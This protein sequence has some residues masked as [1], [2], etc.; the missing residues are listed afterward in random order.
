MSRHPVQKF[1][2]APLFIGSVMFLFLLGLTQYLAYERYLL[3]VETEMHDLYNEA[4]AA[5]SRLQTVLGNSVTTVQTLGFI[6]EH[7]GKP[8]SFDS[9]AT[10]LLRS[11]KY[12]DIIQLVDKDGVITD[13]Y[14]LPGNESVIG[15]NILKDSIRNQGAFAAIKSGAFFWAGPIPLK[16]GGVGII[17]RQPLYRDGQFNGFSAVV[18]KLSTFLKGAG[19]D[20]K[21]ISPYSYQLSRVNPGTHS[22]EFFLPDSGT[23][24]RAYSIPI[25][26]PNGEWKLY[27]SRKTGS[28]FYLTATFSLLGIILSI[29]GGVFAWFMAR[30]PSKLNNLVAEKT[31]QLAASEKYFRA[32]IEQ[33]SDA[34]ILMDRSGKVLYQSPS[35]TRVSGYAPNELLGVD[36]LTLIHPD[37]RQTDLAFFNALRDEPKATRSHMHYLRHKNGNY[38][39]IEGTYTNLLND[40]SV[41]AIVF[42]YHDLS[43]VL[44]EKNLSDS[45]INSLPGV[46]YLYDQS[47][48]FLKWNKNFET[49]SGYSGAEIQH[50]HPL[51]FFDTEE[52]VLLAEKI[53][54][55]F[56]KGMAEVEAPF[57][58][59]SGSKVDYYFNGYLIDLD[60]KDYLV[61]MGIDI[62]QRKKAELA[63]V[64]EKNLSESIINSLPGLFYL[65]DLNGRFLRWNKNFE[66]VS[67]YTANEISQMRVVQF[68]EIDD[69]EELLNKKALAIE[70]GTSEVEAR[71]LTKDKGSITFYF[72]SMLSSYNSGP[73]LLGVGIDITDRK[74]AQEA[75][76][77]RT[78][79]LN[80]RVKELNCLYQISEISN[81]FQLTVDEM[82]SQCIGILALSLQYSAV[83]CGRIVLQG[84]VYQTPNFKEKVWKLKADIVMNDN[85]EGHI[86]VCYLEERPMEY[87]GP[88]FKEER[89]LIDSVARV[90]SAALVRKQAEEGLVRSQN[91]LRQLSAH[92]QTIREEERTSI[93]RE[94]HDELGQQLTGLKMDA[95][96]LKKLSSNQD[97]LD[98]V[99]NMIDLI[100]D[101][102]KTVRRIS[103]ELRPGILDDLGLSSALEWQST[104]FE[105]R[106]GIACTFTAEGVTD[107]FSRDVATGVFRIYQ[108][109]LT[110]VARHAQAKHVTTT[111][112]QNSNQFVL[113]IS[114]DGVGFDMQDAGSK[115]TLG[116]LGMRERAHMFNGKL[117]INSKTGR[118]TTIVLTVPLHLS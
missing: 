45:I 101:T 25:Q 117:E 11:N 80:E 61:G 14:P 107:S 47:G 6:V 31:I 64:A 26:M 72:T 70:K 103:S 90:I 48:S 57:L 27:V 55:V 1:I 39:W 96:W 21:L 56:S 52:K 94:I 87:E 5:E 92:L 60:G 114:D 20:P 111:V 18:I 43:E 110:N 58:H 54:D 112:Q 51:D 16:Q 109:T 41:N 81:N 104:E 36:C 62:T 82:A 30:Q 42:N 23:S 59:K 46:F 35:T 2:T 49:V 22:E 65:A 102:I 85:V 77:N 66:T 3:L 9:I 95:S 91:E 13:V 83:A 118:G 68:V 10:T 69:R 78:M 32:L 98:K 19:I 74:K 4:D 63:I 116:L 113:T 17:G 88:F 84:K 7:Y 67:G 89:W 12:V 115:K 38:V 79:E 75:L 53:K 100:D 15:Y 105:K 34:I 37:Y 99:Q 44:R 76:I 93:A 50:M 97:L 108:E 86:E 71:F 33:S 40:K 106:T 8:A 73:C 29:T 28:A 24:K